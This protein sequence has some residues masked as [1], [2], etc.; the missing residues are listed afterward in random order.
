VF[1]RVL[2]AILVTLGGQAAFAADPPPPKEGAMRIASYNIAMYR[3]RAGQLAE[4]LRSGDS[5]QAKRIA[6]VLQ[7][8]RPDVLLLCEIDYDPEN[9]PAALFAEKYAAVPQ[10]EFG[11]GLLY[12]HR[13]A[14]PVNTGEPSGL[15]LDNDG[16]TDGPA[17]AWGFGRYPGQYGMAVLSRWPIDVASSR[18]FQ[19]LLWSK[20]PDARQ[21][22][23]PATG[24]PYYSAEVWEQLRLPSKTFMDVA[25]K[26]PQGPL[27]LL[28][29]HPTPPV[30]DG[31]EDRN[32]LRNAD[33]VRLVT[34]YAAGRLGDYF[35]DDKGVAGA[36]PAGQPCVVLG[37]LNADPN[38]GD[39]VRDAIRDLIAGPRMAP[40]PMPRSEG[41][42]ASSAD[43]VDLNGNKSGDAANDTGDFSADGHNNLRIDYALPSKELR[44]VGS[45]VYWPKP[46]DE[47]AEA[48]GASDHRL[49][50]VDVAPVER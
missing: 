43:H 14:A 16:K 1:S 24:E 38:D 12:R 20:L 25:V 45:G 30:F 23:D 17:D 46:G 27:R 33:E 50:W 26:T 22:I 9:D 28:C 37:D 13:F 18:T 39:G 48:A 6:E 3:G 44:V 19:N 4:E 36:I 29:S 47:G 41:A 10:T 21:P 40:D 5:Q 35:V 11:H 49:V 15:D 32:G 8:V 31:P 34:E 42:V 7:R 2:V